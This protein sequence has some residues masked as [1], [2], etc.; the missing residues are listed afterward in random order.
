MQSSHLISP[1]NGIWTIYQARKISIIYSGEDRQWNVLHRVWVILLTLPWSNSFWNCSIVSAATMWLFRSSEALTN[2]HKH[3]L[4]GISFLAQSFSLCTSFLT[5]CSPHMAG[6]RMVIN[7]HL[8]QLQYN[9]KFN[10]TCLHFFCA[11]MTATC[12]GDKQ[13][14]YPIEMKWQPK[15]YKCTNPSVRKGPTDMRMRNLFLQ[16]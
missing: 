2:T 9:I 12:T 11:S 7:T 15:K 1:Q 13:Y 4:S 16:G 6:N 5:Q 14:G 3:T 8:L 10:V